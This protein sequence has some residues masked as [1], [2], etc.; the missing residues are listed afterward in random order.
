MK[1]QSNLRPN[2]N[3]ITSGVWTQP[4]TPE[5]GPHLQSLG[6]KVRSIWKFQ[7]PEI[8]S[9]RKLKKD[10]TKNSWDRY[11]LGPVGS[12]LVAVLLIMNFSSNNIVDPT[13][14]RTWNWERNDARGVSFVPVNTIHWPA[15]P[16][17]VL[18]LPI[19]G[20]NRPYYTPLTFLF[21][22]EI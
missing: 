2:L 12:N 19:L 13:S 18:S 15:W 10:P 9:N 6:P 11:V 21:H 7:K 8:P 4:G 20:S 17:S 1:D 5:T 22:W 14:P 16:P 3:S